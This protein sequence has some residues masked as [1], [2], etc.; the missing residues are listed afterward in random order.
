MMSQTPARTLPAARLRAVNAALVVAGSLLMV[1]GAHV[2][3]HVP[4][5]P[6][7]ITGQTL[8]L[9]IVVALLGKRRALSA[10]FLYLAEGATGLHAFAPSGVPGFLALIGPTAGY[11]WSFPLAAY[12]I[13]SLFELGLVDHVIGRA[14][15]TIAGELVVFSL[16]A[17]WLSH[18]VGVDKAF[19]MGVAPFVIGDALK[20][21]IVAVGGGSLTR[22]V[23]AV[24]KA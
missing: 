13:G 15:A 20:V 17:L 14:I 23:P 12:V 2:A 4:F 24:F 6:V 5:S 22:I 21:F 16:G 8:A 9:P 19:L 3:V 1:L 11:L 18:F 10:M 7:P